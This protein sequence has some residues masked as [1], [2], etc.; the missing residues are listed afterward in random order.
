MTKTYTLQVWH[1]LVLVAG[2][3]IVVALLVQAHDGDS[4]RQPAQAPERPG[5]SWL[6]EREAVSI[7]AAGGYP[8]TGENVAYS[9]WGGGACHGY[10]PQD[11]PYFKRFICDAKR[12]GKL[13]PATASFDVGDNGQLI[14]VGG[15]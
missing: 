13:T 11:G 10:G 8:A 4:G 14:F 3:A 15:S 9:G 2:I 12:G 5:G 7:F 1:L 6:T